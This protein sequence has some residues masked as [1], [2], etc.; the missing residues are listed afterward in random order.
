LPASLVG[1]FFCI[2]HSFAP[3]PVVRQQDAS[4]TLTPNSPATSV[5][6]GLDLVG[7]P[8]T[9]GVNAVWF[10]LE[11]VPPEGMLTSFT[12]ATAGQLDVA[13][14]TGVPTPQVTVDVAVDPTIV[15]RAAW[16]ANDVTT[17]AISAPGPL[18]LLL[19]A[20]GLV[21]AAYGVFRSAGRVPAV[22]IFVLAVTF[23]GISVAGMPR[24][25]LVPRTQALA[26]GTLDG[27][28]G[29]GSSIV[30]TSAGATYVSP[31]ISIPVGSSVDRV[32]ASG[33]LGTARVTVRTVAT[34]G[35]AG[36]WLDPT[37]SLRTEADGLQVRVEFES[38][39]ARLDRIR[40]DYRPPLG[41]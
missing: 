40:I 4:A 15:E 16:A 24:T 3:A 18:L 25:V 7:R 17:R 9:T 28:I 29:D 35:A 23:L 41:R 26:D 10:D 37:G 30:A 1:W 11:L 39:G 6:F 12:S 34:D 13:A 33:R 20:A 31:I 21:V 22:G 32:T 2:T 38:K 5:W 36:Q 19:I 8:G 27:A 14:G